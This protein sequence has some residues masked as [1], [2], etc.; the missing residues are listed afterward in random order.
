[1]SVRNRIGLPDHGRVQLKKRVYQREGVCTFQ[2]GSLNVGT[3]K[4]KSREIADLMSRRQ[5]KIL[6]VKEVRWKG[7]KAKEL[8]EGYKLYYSGTKS[9]RN[10]VEII[11]DK[12][13]KEGVYEVD[14]KSDR[15][16]AV[17][18]EVAGPLLIVL[19][20][21][22][23]HLKEVRSCQVIN[24]ESVGPQHRLLV[25]ECDIKIGKR[26]KRKCIRPQKIKWKLK[27]EGPRDEFVQKVLSE[28]KS[29]E[30]VQEWW[31][32]NNKTKKI[33]EEVLGKTSGKG[34]PPEKETWWWEEEVQNKIKGKREAKK[35]WDL[36]GT[37]A[38]REVYRIAR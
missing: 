9:R 34:A 11:L 33:G 6:C 38:A 25:A 24:G 28:L 30:D 5:L 31:E 19:M 10:G 18:L 4:G 7:N 36:N 29:P 22:K 13:L 3:M 14:C 27:E 37:Q 32:V 20:H 17:K 35:N 8:A 15:I 2:T 23:K 1:M 16:M 26:M 12:E 21:L